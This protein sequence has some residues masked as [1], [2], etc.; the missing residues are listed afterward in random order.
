MPG[1]GLIAH[2]RAGTRLLPLARNGDRP[3]IRRVPSPDRPRRGGG[4]PGSED[5]HCKSADKEAEWIE[6]G[7]EIAC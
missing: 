5:G 4:T 2:L 6:V 7:R 3:G 1:T